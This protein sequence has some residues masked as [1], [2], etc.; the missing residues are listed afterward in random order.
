MQAPKISWS[1]VVD[2][3]ENRNPDPRPYIPLP[4]H[5]F[6]EFAHVLFVAV[7]VTFGPRRANTLQR[8]YQPS[9]ATYQGELARL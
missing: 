6:C 3:D 4:G 8:V 2:R 7:A 9:R 1:T 5:V